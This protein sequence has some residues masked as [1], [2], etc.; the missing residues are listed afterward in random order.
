MTGDRIVTASLGTDEIMQTAGYCKHRG[1]AHP[2]LEAI[3]WFAVADSERVPARGGRRCPVACTD[4]SGMMQR[5]WQDL[6]REPR[7]GSAVWIPL[8][9]GLLFLVIA[10]LEDGPS[11]LQYLLGTGLLGL[12]LAEGLP[13]SQWRAA[14]VLRLLSLVCSLISFALFVLR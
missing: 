3:R 4:G 2:T 8:L 13:R 6:W 1:V 14:G 12:A 7:R 11:R 10:V 9:A 5:L